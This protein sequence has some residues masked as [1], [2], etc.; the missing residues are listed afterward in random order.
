MDELGS[1]QQ[2]K[3]HINNTRSRLSIRRKLFWARPFKSHNNT[4][5]NNYKTASQ[6]QQAPSQTDFN[7]FVR[8]YNT[9]VCE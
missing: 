2:A 5:N 8:N 4:E 6:T 1:K 7:L 9:N 3:L